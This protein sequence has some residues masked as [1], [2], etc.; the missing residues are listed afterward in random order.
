[1]ITNLLPVTYRQLLYTLIT[2]LLSCRYLNDHPQYI[3]EGVKL[4]QFSFQIPK[5]LQDNYVRKRPARLSESSDNTNTPVAT[6]GMLLHFRPSISN[7]GNIQKRHSCV[8]II[9]SH[10]KRNYLSKLVL[11]HTRIYINILR[12]ILCIR[13]LEL[14]KYKELLY[15]I[16]IFEDY[17]KRK[18]CFSITQQL[19]ILGSFFKYCDIFGKKM[20]NFS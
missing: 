18:V 19:C 14:I 7:V 16:I 10:L 15:L 9:M 3:R 2:S 11:F 12:F 4:S 20:W 8:K 13:A 1:M 17:H 5:P 6:E